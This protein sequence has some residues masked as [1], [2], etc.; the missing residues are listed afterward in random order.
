VCAVFFYIAT[1]VYTH[2]ALF[3]Y[4]QPYEG[5]GQLMYQLNTAIMVILHVYVTIFSILLGLK[6]TSFTG[7]AFFFIMNII[8]FLVRHRLYATFIAP[9]LNL[10]MTNARIIDEQTKIVEERSR[11][12]HAYKATKKSKKSHPFTPPNTKQTRFKLDMDI[13]SR[14][15]SEML[16]EEADETPETS[17]VY[18][19]RQPFLNKAEL[20]TGPRPYHS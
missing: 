19:Y 8:I 16:D 13:E 17:D 2:Q 3:I 4:A 7:G 5:G 11:L 20:E 18:L 14:Q 9:G 15:R 6:K 10:A 12:F 1:K